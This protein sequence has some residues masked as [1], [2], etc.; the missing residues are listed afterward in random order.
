LTKPNREAP[1]RIEPYDTAWPL[2]FDQERSIL[3]DTLASW[4]AGPIEHIGS[5]AVPGLSAKPVIDIM[6]AVESLD[7]SRP[8]IAALAGIGYVYFPYRADVMHWFCKP[9][10]AMRT[11]HLHLI[12]LDSSLWRQR[13][14]FRDYL[15]NNPAKAAEYAELKHRL[16]HEHE[17]DREAY[18]DA[19]EPF[20]RDVLNLASNNIPATGIQMRRENINSIVV[21]DL[22]TALNAELTE[23]YPEEGATHFRLDPDEVAEGRGAFLVAYANGK[24]VGCGAVRLLDTTTAEI[25]RVFIMPEARGQGISRLILEALE[26]EGRQLGAQRLVL[27][28]GERQAE[29]LGLYD[30]AGFVRIPPFGEYIGSP[31]SV[32]MAKKLSA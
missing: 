29:A 30:K 28:T 19:K 5:T 6:A 2:R 4:L 26:W 8:A 11:H 16:A 12:P 21:T 9:S 18:T 13:I 7:A 3:L 1:V 17:F 20:I 14:T 25:K 15:R 27:E 23:R 24:P 32:C 22:I 31:L 10:T